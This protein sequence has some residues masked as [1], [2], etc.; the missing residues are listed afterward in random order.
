M[1]KTKPEKKERA[2]YDIARAQ[3]TKH[4]NMA[5]GHVRKLQQIVVEIRDI[6][7]D[8]DK[9]LYTSK[10]TRINKELKELESK[11]DAALAIKARATVEFLEGINAESACGIASLGTELAIFSKLVMP[12]PK[13]K[14]KAKG[15]AKGQA[16]SKPSPTLGMS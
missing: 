1:P 5:K 10:A 9:T 13:A 8:E 12:P 2:P 4:A 15:Q 6:A 14:A 16:K 3:T 11:L 7:N